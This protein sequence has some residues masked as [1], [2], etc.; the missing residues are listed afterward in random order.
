MNDAAGTQLVMTVGAGIK[1]NCVLLNR[2][3]RLPA[4]LRLE[5]KEAVARPKHASRKLRA[6]PWLTA[7]NPGPSRE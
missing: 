5:T 3:W 6:D 2:G 4:A 1:K 7:R